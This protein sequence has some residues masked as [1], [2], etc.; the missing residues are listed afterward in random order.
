M[1]GNIEKVMNH[2]I[3]T[4]PAGCSATSTA[5]SLNPLLDPEAHEPLTARSVF[6]DKLRCYKSVLF[7]SGE[8]NFCFGLTPDVH[9]VRVNAVSLA[10]AFNVAVTD[11]LGCRARYLPLSAKPTGFSRA[12]TERLQAVDVTNEMPSFRICPLADTSSNKLD[13]PSRVK[14]LALHPDTLELL[15]AR[16]SEILTSST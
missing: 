2:D 10:L 13:R 11:T 3:N 16:C 4:L 6:P 1:P 9:V 5:T 15:Q 12:G 14:A 8:I 7:Q